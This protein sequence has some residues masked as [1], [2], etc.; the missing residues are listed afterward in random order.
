[1]PAQVELERLFELATDLLATVRADGYVEHVNPAWERALGW[2][3]DQLRTVRLAEFVH[4]DDRAR[5]EA[6]AAHSAEPGYEVVNFEARFA[7]KAGGWRWL[8]WS[9]H[10]DGET[11]FAVAKD[12]TDRKRLETRAFEDPL[13]HLPNRAVLLDRLQ[14]ARARQA[15]SGTLMAVLFLDLDRFKV[16]NDTFGHDVGDRLLQG[17]AKRLRLLVRESDTIA[18]L[19][20]DEFVIL[21][22]DVGAPEA[23]VGL[24]ERIVGAF[25]EPQTVAQEEIVVRASVGVTLTGFGEARTPE[26][27]LREADTAMYRAK[28][29]GRSRFAVFDAAMR[30]EVSQQRQIGVDL[31]HALERDEFR[32]EY[33]PLVKVGDGT[34]AGA[35]ALLRWD[36][37][38]RGAIPPGQFIPLAEENG[39][40]APIGE[41]VLR[42]ACAQAAGWRKTGEQ[43]SVCV[44]V[45]PLQLAQPGFAELVRVIV[46]GA[47]LPPECVTLEMV[48]ASVVRDGESIARALHE[49]RRLGVRL[50]LDDF[51]KGATSLSYF[52][53]IPIDVVKLDRSFA[54]GLRDGVEDRAIVAGVVS[55][56]DEMG[57]E[58][59][60]EGIETADQLAELRQLG[61]AYAQGFLFAP[62]GPAEHLRLGGYHAEARPGLGDPF[63]IREFMRQIGIPARIR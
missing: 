56:A 42:T 14:H 13:T 59:V 44:N 57:I 61:C 34:I 21:A 58:V 41:W 19:G 53:D 43:L 63:V 55:L 7:H 40:I 45:S 20:G 38:D 11:W 9:A 60:A 15:R 32:L 30:E 23:A 49:L 35:E 16:A 2:T 5:T 51:G 12:I 6:L 26:E 50:A 33:Q 18:R 4:P 52:R 22:E 39:L 10:S 31:R 29:A 62:P 28:G 17:A 8:L 54:A 46:R 36:H 25:R 27:L 1:M 3:P 47:G 37:P 24:A 48:E